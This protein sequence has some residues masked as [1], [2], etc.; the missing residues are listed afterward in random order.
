MFS[1]RLCRAGLDRTSQLPVVRLDISQIELQSTILRRAFYDEPQFKLLLPDE[2]MRRT[3]LPQLFRQVACSSQLFGEI[4]TTENLELGAVWMSRGDAFAFDRLFRTD[5]LANPFKLGWSNLRRWINLSTRLQT[6]HELF[7]QG[8]P[9][10][11]HGSRT[12]TIKTRRRYRY[13]SVSRTSVLSRDLL[14]KR[15]PF[16]YGLWLSS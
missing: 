16:L 3:L 14:R 9:L 7:G 13:R 8:T 2:E 1:H 15:F 5:I 11:P 4:Y 12:E 10:V 6:V